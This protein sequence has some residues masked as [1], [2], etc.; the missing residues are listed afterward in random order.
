MKSRHFKAIFILLVLIVVAIIAY[1][2]I[3]DNINIKK[4]PT[5]VSLQKYEFTNVYLIPISDGYIMIDNAYEKEYDLFLKYLKEIKISINQI[6]YILITHHHDDHVGLLNQIVA[7]NPSVQII[8]S[9]ETAELLAYGKNNMNNGGGIVNSYIYAL[10]KIKQILTPDW[11]LSFPAYRFREN[12]IILKE[13]NADLF[14]ILGINIKSIN[15][16]GHTSDSITFIYNN[17][18]AFCGDLASNYLNWAGARYL[19]LFNE[20]IDSVYSSWKK[21]INLEIEIIATA[22]GKPFHINNLINN[23]HANSQDEIVRFF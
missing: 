22:H 11:N 16:P 6:K 7:A 17:N 21:L 8:M 18:I 19:T 3:S 20:D 13:D 14:P 2:I 4:L 23:L 5:E 1:I 15:T 12:D 9:E 10:F